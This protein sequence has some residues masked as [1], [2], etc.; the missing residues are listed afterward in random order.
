MRTAT[1]EITKK[2]K[3][4]PAKTAVKK[5]AMGKKATAKRAKKN[6]TAKGA[7][8]KASKAT[9]TKNEPKMSEAWS[10][11]SLYIHQSKDPAHSPG[12][13]RIELKKLNQKESEV[14]PRSRS[15]WGKKVAPMNRRVLTAR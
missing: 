3:R 13:R 8:S 5:S 1:K 9:K 11:E 2:G 6:I 10:A 14:D 12:H 7:T 15:Q 4:K